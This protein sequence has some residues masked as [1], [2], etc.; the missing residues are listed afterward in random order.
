MDANGSRFHLLLGRDDWA[1]CSVAG[2]KLRDIW[3]PSPPQ[4]GAGKLSWRD[5]RQELTLEQRLLR[6]VAAPRDTFPSVSNRR[7]AAGDRFGNFY[8][9]DESERRVRVL[10]SGSGQS[11]DF[12][13][14]P[15]A[16]KCKPSRPKRRGDFEPLAPRTIENLKLSGLAVTADHYLVVGTVEP[17]SLLIFDLHAG[18]EPRQLVWPANVPFAPLDMAAMPGGGVAILDGKNFCYW[19]LDR[20]FN[21]LGPKEKDTLLAP[22]C[23]DGF[24]PR[25]GS[26]IH[27]SERA[28]FPAPIPLLV[29]PLQFTQPIAIEAL[30]DGTVLILDYDPSR[31]FS[32]IYRYNFDEQLP[33]L[34]TTNAILGLIE[35]ERKDDVSL[36][37][38]DIAFVPQHDEGGETIPDR[39]YVAAAD[40]NQSFVFRVC[41]RQQRLELQPIAEYLPMR[42]F[43]GKG[44]VAAGNGVYYDFAD[45]WIPLVKQR[46]PRYVAEAT[47]ETPAFDGIEPNCIWHR[48]L[49]DAAIPPETKV[50]VW[51][52]A[53][54]EERDLPLTQWQPEPPL[55]LRGDG[56]ELPFLSLPKICSGRLSAGLP[57]NGQLSSTKLKD[58][59]GT[60]E[61]L[62]QRARGRFL[63]L[64]L[65]LSGNE[66]STP[67]LRALRSYYPRFSYLANYLP[68]VYREDE[69]SAS[70]LDR[71]LANVEGIYTTLED[72]IAAAQVLFDVRSAPTETL[73][74]LATW[75]G[76]ALD[77]NWDEQRRRLFITHAMEFFQYRGTIRGLTMA[78]HLA[79]DSCVDETIFETGTSRRPEDIRIVEKYLT[80]T[81]P[82]V[83]FGDPTG[84]DGLRDVL[85]RARWQPDQGRANLNQRYTEFKNP[86]SAGAADAAEP[87]LET[88]LEYP[89]I[90]PAAEAEASAWQQFS[91]D[92]LGFVPATSATDRTAW[93][94]FLGSR[95]GSIA[96]LNRSHQTGYEKFGEVS[97]PPDLPSLAAVLKDWLDFVS[98]PNP[99]V[100]PQGR[101]SW[102]D[103]LARRYQRINAFNDA[104]G[105]RWTSFDVVSLPD[106]LPPDGDPLRDWYQFEG[107]VIQMQR[108]AH[109]FT[110]LLPVPVSLAFSPA[111]HQLRMDLSRRIVE[112]EKPA[113][114]VFDVK[115]YWAIF[116]IG[117]ARLE[118]DTL[119]EQGSRAPELMPGLILDQ[120]FV[121]ESY[122]APPVP[123]NASDRLILGRDSLRNDPR[124]E[125]RS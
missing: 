120:G 109:R 113:H 93:Q 98:E 124:E 16:G 101:H 68:G 46:R 86:P 50:E 48:L 110:V 32:R 82:G 60:W 91:V 100:T 104:Y 63:Q 38:Y 49:F 65:R 43:G 80:R 105:T 59:D 8:W 26:F 119:I 112:L 25:D 99:A 4:S 21:V 51:S 57:S 118:L 12:W 19:V 24:Q 42:L 106:L 90:P 23:T 88:L 6:F 58:G 103:F 18:G 78:L 108:T 96:A 56:S 95:Y 53:A 125:G 69:Q 9:I 14:L 84:P 83:I 61:L 34:L 37:G 66:R 70:F 29:S 45:S 47:L 36:V 44:I 97:L 1:E 74:W 75:F 10:S 20:K 31:R 116:R 92:T 71:F 89:I 77:P 62:F 87:A 117:E 13:P 15:E 79:L 55:Y 39:L 17:G 28:A 41:L 67:R 123:E 54:D 94:V 33:D 3:Q 7:G 76:V 5:E 122:L 27:G 73:G 72:R 35:D 115:F 107:I 30:S 22:A 121:G 2:A 85:P 111:E 40:G 11:S 64:K 102:Q 114:T 52:R 81:M